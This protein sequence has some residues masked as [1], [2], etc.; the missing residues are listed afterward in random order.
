MSKSKKVE[1]EEGLGYL[2]VAYK[3]IPVKPIKGI[4][5]KEGDREKNIQESSK[6][7]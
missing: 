5:K 3:N 7:V 2:P 1:E 4:W 6:S